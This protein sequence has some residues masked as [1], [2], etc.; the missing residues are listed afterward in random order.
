MS[1]RRKAFYALVT[2]FTLWIALEVFLRFFGYGRFI[3]YEQD[4]E[5]LWRPRPNQVGTTVVGRQP[6]TINGQGLR[7]RIDLEP[8]N[9]Q[10]H[11]VVAFGDSITMGWGVDDKS[12]TLLCRARATSGGVIR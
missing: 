3:V 5:L 8:R 11:R 2:C 9:P 1:W 12:H 7:Y 6:I 10:E 4:S